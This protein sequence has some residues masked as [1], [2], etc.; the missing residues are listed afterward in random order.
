[1]V[2]FFCLLLHE[3]PFVIL[4]AAEL[5]VE[6]RTDP[7]SVAASTS[8]FVFFIFSPHTLGLMVLEQYHQD[9]VLLGLTLGVKSLKID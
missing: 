1:V 6:S 2:L 3:V 7:T 4:V 8:D 9:A 5:S